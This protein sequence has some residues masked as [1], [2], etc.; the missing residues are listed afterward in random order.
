MAFKNRIRLPFKITRA[1]FPEER[2]SFRKANGETKTL[3]VVIRKE[4]EGE[5][6]YLPE[7]WHQKLTIALSHD[8]V[9]IEGDK[10]LGGVSKSGE[11]NIEWV[12]FMDYPT[13]KANF[14]VEVTPFDE[15]N[16]NCMT[17]EEATQLSLEDD[18][19]TG[20]YGALEE[21][22]TYEW[23]LAENDNICCYPAVFSIVWLNTDYLSDYSLNDETG[24]ISVTIAS[25]V[26]SANGLK[27][28]TYRVTCPNGGYDE[29]DVF[30]N[31]QGS[32]EGCLAP[33]DLIAL[34]SD[35]SSIEYSWL[36]P[37][38]GATIQ[39]EIYEGS[40]P[41][42]SPVQ[43]NTA[44]IA[45]ELTVTGLNP[46]QEYYFR[47]RTVCEEAEEDFSNWVSVIASTIPETDLCGEYVISFTGGVPGESTQVTYRDC[48]LNFQS[49]MLFTG[50]SVTI[51]AGQTSPGNPVFIG[52]TPVT[53][54][55]EITYN[56]LC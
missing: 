44:V 16:S 9:T 45:G 50:N 17:C 35:T 31:I 22:E 1:Q 7:G 30:G 3:S 51:C 23:N 19:I 11:Y 27:I 4:Y 15:T 38:V 13:A 56:G 53:G 34:T 12:D 24:V 52:H 20:I 28:A 55:I 46:N 39:W 43:T 5:T 49:T 8:D 37:F 25:G 36:N 54:T 21:G 47:I 2:T 32:E 26:V 18:T 48:S 10:Y 42:G 29:A 40:L 41:V 33:T 6:D 14:K